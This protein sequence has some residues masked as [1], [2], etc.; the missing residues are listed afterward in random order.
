MTEDG[1]TEDGKW[2]IVQ[3]SVG[4]ETAKTTATTSASPC[5]AIL[6]GDDIVKVLCG[7]KRK[8]LQLL[9]DR[10]QRL[11]HPHCVHLGLRQ[12]I[13]QVRSHFVDKEIQKK[14]FVSTTHLQ[15]KVT[16]S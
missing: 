15:N 5:Y 10:V 3:C 12:H 1:R 7:Q 2:K 16:L 9:P 13:F 8:A 4:P 6:K 11:A 14:N